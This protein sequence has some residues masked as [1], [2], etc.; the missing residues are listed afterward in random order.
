MALSFATVE[1]AYAVF[2]IL[3]KELLPE[4]RIPSWPEDMG[5]WD[6]QKRENPPLLTVH[7]WGKKSDDGWESIA[8]FITEPSEELK[9]RFEEL[10][11]EI[12]I[13]NTHI[14]EPYH[15][16]ESIWAIGWF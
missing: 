4:L 6:W 9:K 10:L 7:G 16:N 1:K 3:K 12:K 5:D 14:N 13:P 8:F 15:K 2:N 11:T